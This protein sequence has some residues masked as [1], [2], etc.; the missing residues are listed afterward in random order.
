[1]GE[2][3]RHGQHTPDGATDPGLSLADAAVK[4]WES[5]LEELSSC[6]RQVVTGTCCGSV[7]VVVP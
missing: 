3:G 1:M 7:G 6:L 5:F 4:I 2:G